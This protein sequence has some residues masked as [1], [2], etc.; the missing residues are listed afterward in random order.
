MIHRHAV[1]M[2]LT[3]H[4]TLRCKNCSA[5]SEYA[6]PKFA[7][8]ETFVNDISVLSKVLHTKYFTFNGGEPLQH[9][10]IL[11]FLDAARQSNISDQVGIVT[12]GQLLTR[13]DSEFFRR[14]DYLQISVY[15]N[16]N[17]DYDKIWQHLQK[18]EQE[19]GVKFEVI[20]YTNN[21]FNVAFTPVKLSDDGARHSF[22]NCKM[23]HDYS[24]HSVGDGYYYK[25]LK[26]HIMDRYLK[27][28]AVSTDVVYKETDGVILHVDNLEQRLTDYL[29]REEPLQSCYH[30]YGNSGPEEKHIQLPKKLLGSR[31]N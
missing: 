1:G 22:V 7:S 28:N 27:D 16:V 31:R 11:Q 15:P 30:C 3:E 26:P 29:N 6:P 9:P 20:K 4:C 23:T 5:Y 19:P 14:I 17:I 13:F 2:M 18:M 24:C 21:T 25:C 8:L 12:N 10:Q